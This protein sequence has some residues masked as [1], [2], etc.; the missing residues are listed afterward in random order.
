[1]SGTEDHR[2]LLRPTEPVVKSKDVD[3]L[4]LE[5]LKQKLLLLFHIVIVLDYVVQKR[6]SFLG[7]EVKI[8]QLGAVSCV[9]LRASSD[10]VGLFPLDRYE[11]R[12]APEVVNQVEVNFALNCK[13]R[14]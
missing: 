1:M 4:V 5:Q 12:R 7:L 6:L 14:T 13:F 3:E 9:D 11:Q 10:S 8:K 2:V